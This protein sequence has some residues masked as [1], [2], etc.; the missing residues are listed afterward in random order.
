MTVGEFYKSYYEMHFFFTSF[1]HANGVWPKKNKV[2]IHPLLPMV[3]YQSFPSPRQAAF[4]TAEE[5][6]LPHVINNYYHHRYSFT[7]RTINI[8]VENA[9]TYISGWV[10]SK[11]YDGVD[12]DEC[13]FSLVDVAS[14]Q[15]PSYHLLNIRNQGVYLIPSVGVVKVTM[16]F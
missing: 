13:R 2:P 5:P 8:L 9:V 16:Q 11:L 7:S 3:L 12:C 15:R 4:T 10:V 14:A 6:H 1:F